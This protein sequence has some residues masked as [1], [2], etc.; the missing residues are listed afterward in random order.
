MVYVVNNFLF[1]HDPLKVESIVKWAT[2]WTFFHLFFNF[3]NGCIVN[4]FLFLRPTR[5]REGRKMNHKIK[6][7]PSVL[8]WFSKWYMLSTISCFIRPARL[9]ACRKMNYKTKIF[10]SVLIVFKIVCVVSNFQFLTTRP[11]SS[12]S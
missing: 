6:I 3:Q 1:L 11:T 12:G 10:P 5:R 2:K 8:F 7:F 4:N 9:R